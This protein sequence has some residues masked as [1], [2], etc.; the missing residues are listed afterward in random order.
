MFARPA[1]DALAK[2]GPNQDLGVKFTNEMPAPNTQADREDLLF[3]A[4]QR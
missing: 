3:E 1:A 2:N 4:D